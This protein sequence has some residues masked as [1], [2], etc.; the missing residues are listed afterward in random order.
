MLGSSTGSNEVD[1]AEEIIGDTGEKRHHGLRVTLR[2]QARRAFIR[3]RARWSA[4]H[5]TLAQ[6]VIASVAAI[7]I[8]GLVLVA[9]YSLMDVLFG[10]GAVKIHIRR[11]GFMKMHDVC[12]ASPDPM[13]S[14]DVLHRAC[15][16][17]HEE[18][19]ASALNDYAEVYMENLLG[20]VSWLPGCSKAAEYGAFYVLVW[21]AC[22]FCVLMWAFNNA[23]RGES[24]DERRRA[25]DNE[26]MLNQTR[27][28]RREEEELFRQQQQQQQQRRSM[29]Q[30]L[31]PDVPSDTVSRYK[32]QLDAEAAAVTTA[33]NRVASSS[34]SSF[35]SITEMHE[36]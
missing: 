2:R 5:M 22:I 31:S 27:Q 21:V 12:K 36:D 19:H 10:N 20:F 9:V 6:W 29:A 24:E 13:H 15:L 7:M 32:K 35:A 17:A 23:K 18:V 1:E 25:A 8:L 28:I 11:D 3:A 16:R 34:S 33:R 26:I 30:L 14:A 4:A